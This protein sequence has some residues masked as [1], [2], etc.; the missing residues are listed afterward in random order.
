MPM[1][2]PT[3]ADSD[4][5]VSISR[6]AP[7]RSWSPSVTRKTP[8][9]RPTSSPRMT[10]RLSRSISW[11]KARLMA[12]TMLSCAISELLQLPGLPW[13]DHCAG[14]LE[15][16]RHGRRGNG[17]HGLYR[18]DNGRSQ[19]AF[20]LDPVFL[21]P[22]SQPRHVPLQ[23]QQR[24]P[25][26]P[27]SHFLRGTVASGIIGGGMVGHA[28]GETLDKGRPSSA[29]G[30]VESLGRGPV[31][32]EDVVAVYLYPVEAVGNRL[33]RQGGGSGL[34]LQRNGNRPLIVLADEDHRQP[35]NPCHVESLVEV[36]LGGSAIAEI[37]NRNDRV[38]QVAG[39]HGRP[40]R[41]GDMGP[42]RY[43]GG[44]DVEPVRCYLT[45]LVAGPVLEELV[46][47]VAEGQIDPCF[48]KGRKNPIGWGERQGAAYLSGL[49]PQDGGIG[50]EPPFPLQGQG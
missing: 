45:A 3:M 20:D 50:A 42:D 37:G 26:P 5:G 47:G 9:S 17:F 44:E 41:M 10:I 48:A 27:G 34:P 13:A 38:S 1:A 43:A 49:L 19:A 40:G 11:R 39:G 21:A 2:A 31:D 7:K 8:P 25:G 12:C 4:R 35:E 22:E 18:L 6:S 28:V 14:V 23:T 36:P 16:L 24:V 33:L 30:L 29:A 15:H 32:R 46:D